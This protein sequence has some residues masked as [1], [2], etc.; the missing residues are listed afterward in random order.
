[1]SLTSQQR[2][3]PLGD[4]MRTRMAGA[5]ELA[6]QI[7]T[8]LAGAGRPVQPTGADVDLRHRA[9]IGGTFGHRL[10]DFLTQHAPPYYALYGAV[11]AELADWPGIHH[12]AAGFPTHAALAP[13]RRCRACDWRPTRAGWVDVGP[14]MPT[15]PGYRPAGV[16]AEFTTRARNYLALHAPPGQVASSMGA[17]TTLARVCWVLNAWEGA[18]RGGHLD[19]E[20]TTDDVPK[21]LN[22]ASAP[23]VAELLALITRAHTSG[24]LTQ[25]RE[26]AADPA[27]GQD[28]GIAGPV[29]IPHWADGDLLVGETLLEVKTVMHARNHT[30]TAAWL[31][32]LLAYTWLD[33]P[34]RYR[35]RRVGLYL[36][37]HGHLITWPLHTFTHTLLATTDP[38]KVA[39]T[40][41]EFR[42]LAAHVITDEGADPSNCEGP[43]HPPNRGPATEAS[44]SHLR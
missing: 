1:M 12:A 36:A 20:F 5:L 35:I 42:D 9:D 23:V 43:T 27:P 24:A 15:P 4:W 25:L 16:V 38:R 8:R 11:N 22:L 10:I 3:G 41:A 18:Y 19:L 34:D 2:G 32:Q 40:Y 21:L 33:G 14:T 30:R 29:L 39:A 37:R 28:L 26:L 44:P 13:G 7:D 6:G 17:E 31:R